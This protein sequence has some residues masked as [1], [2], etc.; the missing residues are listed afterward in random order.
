MLTVFL[1]SLAGIPP[2]AGFW[3]KYYIFYAAIKENLIWLSIVAILLSLLSIYYYL[4]IIIYMWFKDAA[5]NDD[6]NSVKL[7]PLN[8]AVLGVCL[9]GTLLFGVYPQLFFTF[10]GFVIK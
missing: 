10:F 7:S 8:I 6:V 3:G 5:E 4:K 9:L 1:F 2:F